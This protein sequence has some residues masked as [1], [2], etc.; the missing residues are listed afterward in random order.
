M[1]NNE[2]RCMLQRDEAIR[3]GMPDV[4]IIL[5]LDIGTTSNLACVIQGSYIEPSL[6]GQHQEKST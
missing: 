3:R 2:S 4:V 1:S 6:G 5:V